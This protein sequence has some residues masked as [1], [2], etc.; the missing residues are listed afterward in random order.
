LHRRNLALG[1]K[2]N[3]TDWGADGFLF[4]FSGFWLSRLAANRW[5]PSLARTTSHCAVSVATVFTR[6]PRRSL[7]SLDSLGSLLGS[8]RFIAAASPFKFLSDEKTVPSISGPL[9]LGKT[10]GNPSFCEFLRKQNAI[11]LEQLALPSDYTHKNSTVFVNGS[12]IGHALSSKST[13]ASLSA[14][15]K[16]LIKKL[17]DLNLFPHKEED[18]TETAALFARVTTL[19]LQRYADFSPFFFFF[20]CALQIFAKLI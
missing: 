5:F 20:I 16:L 11:M 15:E 10:M 4:P 14:D 17:S 1:C 19:T 8:S 3:E 18:V 2:G 13:R 6:S 12:Y 9:S 7:P